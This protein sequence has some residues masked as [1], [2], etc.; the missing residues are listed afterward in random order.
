M[1]RQT[2]VGAKTLPDADGTDG[3]DGTDD[4]GRFVGLSFF[5]FFVDHEKD[6][7]HGL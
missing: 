5:V 6:K 2:A 3:T 4:T 7:Q 1:K